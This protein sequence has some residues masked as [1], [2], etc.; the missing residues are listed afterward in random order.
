MRLLDL[1][2]T[3]CFSKDY[4]LPH[5]IWRNQNDAVCLLIVECFNSLCL[6]VNYIYVILVLSFQ[7]HQKCSHNLP[8]PNL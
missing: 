2:I 1:T 3:V 5:Q 6:F 8:P 7:L 4:C